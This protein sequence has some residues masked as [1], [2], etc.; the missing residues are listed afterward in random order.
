MSIATTDRPAAIGSPDVGKPAVK[1]PRRLRRRGRA[2]RIAKYAL[3]VFALALLSSIAAWPEI[4]RTIERGRVTW[5]RLT[6]VEGNG[7][8]R[9]PHYRG[10]DAQNQPYMISAESADRAGPERYNLRAPR[11]DL[12]LHNGTWL[13]VQARTGVY[14]QKSDQLDL[15]Q[16]VTLYRQDGTILF[17]QAATADMKLGVVTSGLYT[18]VEGPFGTLDAE[19]FTLLDRGAIVQFHGPAKL[20]MNGAH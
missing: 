5:H 6:M 10:Y 13:Q 4:S 18:H 20:V 2:V 8:M 19:G 1:L 17:T 9:N 11:G 14:V 16:D 12:T 15:A 3:P 7:A